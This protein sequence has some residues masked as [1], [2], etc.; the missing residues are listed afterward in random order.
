MPK[1]ILSQEQ[2]KLL[3][4]NKDLPVDQYIENFWKNIEKMSIMPMEKFLVD[5]RFER[6]R[7]YIKIN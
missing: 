1:I 7:I 2:Y 6:Y 4:N 3:E 5:W